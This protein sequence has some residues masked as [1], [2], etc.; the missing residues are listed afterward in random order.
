MV[1]PDEQTA[2]CLSIFSM[3]EYKAAV[4]FVMEQLQGGEE[5]TGTG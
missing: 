3:Q 4:D 1:T 2:I 5:P